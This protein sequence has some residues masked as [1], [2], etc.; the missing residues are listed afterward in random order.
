MKITVVGSAVGGVPEL[1][2]EEDVVPPGDANALAAKIQ[3]V[4]ADRD[5]LE[6]M[7]AR[8]LEL[9]R[10]FR[11]DLLEAQ[12]L[13]FYEELRRVCRSRSHASANAG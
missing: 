5:R 1:L 12:R 7:A 4:L 13:A 11:E 9:A 2:P 6:R 10:Q 8:N 3:D